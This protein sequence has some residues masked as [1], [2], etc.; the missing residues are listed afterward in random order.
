MESSAFWLNGPPLSLRVLRF[1]FPVLCPWTLSLCSVRSVWVMAQA[2]FSQNRGFS[3]HLLPQLSTLLCPGYAGLIPIGLICLVSTV[4]PPTRL[5]GIMSSSLPPNRDWP[6]SPTCTCASCFCMQLDL[7]SLNHWMSLELAPVAILP[8]VTRL[9]P[10]WSLL[11]ASHFRKFP[12]VMI[13]LKFSG[14][15]FILFL[16]FSNVITLG[17]IFNINIVHVAPESLNSH[18]VESWNLF[19][20]LW[21]IWLSPDVFYWM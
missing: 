16:L 10:T 6:I 8:W 5:S 9:A 14:L 21:N 12:H 11:L 15:Y 17:D 19:I 4:P 18:C 1:L 7:K 20:H 13:D 2:C 3:E